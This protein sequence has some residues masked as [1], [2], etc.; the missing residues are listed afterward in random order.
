MT[1]MKATAELVYFENSD[2]YTDKSHGCHN[3]GT[4]GGGGDCW[5][6]PGGDGCWYR[7]GGDYCKKKTPR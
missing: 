2:V 7:P 6:R 5:Y 4:G 3:S 1:Y